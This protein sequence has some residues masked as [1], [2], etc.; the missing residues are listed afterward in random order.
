[1]SLFTSNDTIPVTAEQ[2]QSLDIRDNAGYVIS[3]VAILGFSVL[4]Y[5]QARKRNVRITHFLHLRTNGRHPIDRSTS[6]LS[7]LPDG[8]HRITELSSIYQER[9][10]SY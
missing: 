3:G 2:T 8:S 10:R 7:A 1:M 6:R 5:L 4:Q 9:D